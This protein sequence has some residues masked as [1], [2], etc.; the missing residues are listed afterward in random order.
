MDID[1]ESDLAPINIS[2]WAF[3]GGFCAYAIS[4]QISCADLYGP[5]RDK[6]CL[7]GLAR[8]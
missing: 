1:D 2:A 3:K 8:K 6:T 7:C 5:H 4:T